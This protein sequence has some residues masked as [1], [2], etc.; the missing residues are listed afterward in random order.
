MHR[1]FTYIA[2]ILLT[3]GVVDA[4]ACS[5]LSVPDKQRH[6]EASDVF[7]GTVVETKLISKTKKFDEHEISIDYVEAKV[8]KTNIIKGDPS[9]HIE[10]LDEVANGANCAIGLITGRDYLF[11]LY[12]DNV[13]SICEGSRLYNE[14]ADR[15]LI[16]EMTSY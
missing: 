13:L 1:S 5:C 8:R 6:T 2:A 11:Y 9:D 16:E 7:V 14:F 10:V 15:E 4:Q 3:L 12:D